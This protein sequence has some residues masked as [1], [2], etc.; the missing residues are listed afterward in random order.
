MT[1]KPRAELVQQFKAGARPSQSDFADL[2]ASTLNKRDDQLQGRWEAGAA[3]RKGDV[4]IHDRTFWEL[5]AEGICSENGHP[6]S[7]DNKD[8]LP[9]LVPAADEDWTLVGAQPQAE[10]QAEGDGLESEG[11]PADESVPTTMHANPHVTRV[12]IGTRKPAALLDLFAA[13]R[14]RLLLGGNDEDT[15]P[16]RLVNLS[17]GS[18]SRQLAIGI[19]QDATVLVT[20][21]DR[22]FVFRAR[23][24]SS[25]EQGQGNVDRRRVALGVSPEDEARL[26][27]GRRPQAYQLDVHG[28]SRLHGVYIDTD[29]ANLCETSPLGPVLE[30]LVQLTPVTFRWDPATGLEPGSEQIGL[31]AQDVAHGFP[32]A[33]KATGDDS[34]AVSNHALIAVLLKAVQEQQEHIERL[35]NRLDGLERQLSDRDGASES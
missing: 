28:L 31:V 25:D 2:I 27:V 23:G 30:Q 34:I 32:Q 4:V 19:T 24:D 5:D 13:D 16:L 3:Y 15:C 33:V 18:A 17:P 20:D 35:K 8:W 10:S 22:G 7:T 26:G 11:E 14:A 29:Q 12:G 9:L 21:A 1:L 6:P